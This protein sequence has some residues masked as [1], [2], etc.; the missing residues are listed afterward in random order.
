MHQ[1]E[2]A[3]Q[4]KWDVGHH[5]PEIRDAQ[6]RPL[7]GEAMVNLALQ[8]RRNQQKPGQRNRGKAEQNGEGAGLNR[9]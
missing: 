6:Q 9:G 8:D 3:D 5:V 2:R 4:N 7:I 1:A